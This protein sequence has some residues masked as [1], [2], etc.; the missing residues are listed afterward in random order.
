MIQQQV[1]FFFPSR[2]PRSTANLIPKLAHVLCWGAR[3]M[4]GWVELSLICHSVHPLDRHY[5]DN[6]SICSEAQYFPLVK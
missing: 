2:M 4:R 6:D 1:L 5:G 3:C